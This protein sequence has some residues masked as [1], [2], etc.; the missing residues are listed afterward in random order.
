MALE[1]VVPAAAGHPAEAQEGTGRD[2]LSPA[3][4]SGLTG[5]LAPDSA[6][7]DPATLARLSVGLRGLADALSGEQVRLNQVLHC[8]LQAVYEA[9]QCRRVLLCLRDAD[10]QRLVGRFGLGEG[11]TALAARV[12]VPLATRPQRGQAPDLV[13]QACLAGE[14]VWLGDARQ[15]ALAAQ[16]PA[17]L[18]QG[19]APAS[20]LVL[21]LRLRGA[22][23]AMV[24]ADHAQARVL[25]E[26]ERALLQS[27]RN[28]ALVA[29]KL[30]G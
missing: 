14:D 29:F 3:T 20:C 16:L 25:G 11:V 21:P 4:S 13:A 2:Q 27:L 12:Q 10:G 1:A 6:A 22:P 15:P 24:Y 5:R 26:R 23:L 19:F 9:L 17:W 18:R 30:L 8:W 7:D 28:Q